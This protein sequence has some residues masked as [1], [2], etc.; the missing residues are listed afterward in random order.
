M[1][2]QQT[3]FLSLCLSQDAQGLDICRHWLA[4]V[5]AARMTIMADRTFLKNLIFIKCQTVP[6]HVFSRNIPTVYNIQVL[7]QN[8]EEMRYQPKAAC[9]DHRPL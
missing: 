5:V 3:H 6:F 4:F 9:Q 7:K 1:C 8:E 2:L